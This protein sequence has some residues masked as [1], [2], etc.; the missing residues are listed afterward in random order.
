[1][2]KFSNIFKPL[3]FT[4][5]LIVLLLISSRIFIPKNN[6]EEFGMQQISANGILGEK[7]NTIDV[8]FVGDSI[9]Y[10]S[11]FPLQMYEEY[12]FTSYTMG[13]A[14][15]KIYETY[16][17]I[18]EA[19]KTQKPKVVVF[20]TGVLVRG[21]PISSAIT[22]EIGNIFPIIEY[23]NRWKNLS[24][25]DLNTKISYTYTSPTKGYKKIDK[26]V[27]AQDKDY[28]KK[29]DKIANIS[30]RNQFYLER[31]IELC[32]KNDIE[33]MM[34]SA[35]ATKS[36]NY[37]RHNSFKELAKTKNLNYIDLNIIDDIDINWNKDFYDG[38]EHLNYQG[39]KKVS[40]YMGAYLQETYNLTDHRN[41]SSFQSWNEAL[42]NFKK[43]AKRK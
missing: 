36:M 10:V 31:I 30:K 28:M 16:D 42:M 27:K 13:S 39:A 38:G 9:A 21:Y 12:G 4:I 24:I 35:I 34:V 14:G 33:F 8:L 40:A 1:M 17:F 32:Q 3:L 22:N 15:Q 37:A 18:V 5:I 25:N 41:D 6:I 2:A 20:E 11:F 19:L 26:T 43:T 29:D 7:E 23:H